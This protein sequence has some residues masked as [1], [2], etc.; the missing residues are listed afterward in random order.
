M[1]I[2]PNTLRRAASA[3]A[4]FRATDEAQ[5]AEKS[6]L[7]N[8][9]HELDVVKNRRASLQEAE[10]RDAAI[11]YIDGE[12]AAPIDKKRQNEL[13][14]LQKSIPALVAALPLQRQRIATCE[15]EKRRLK[16]PLASEIVSLVSD[17][18]APALEHVRT[19]IA[20]LDE[21]LSQLLAADIIRTSLLDGTFPVNEGQAPPFNGRTI[22]EK[23]I[24]ALPSKL[25][26]E[27]LSKH[28]LYEQARAKASGII[29]Q[30]KEQDVIQ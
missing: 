1:D 15:A 2:N 16:G 9:E 26:S 14:K 4:A 18:Q 27:G 29:N 22:V 17:I 21:A 6:K 5:Q 25:M 7:A 24:A 28:R 12:A 8:V 3:F 19:A 11:R 13:E 30:I 23:L 10:D 20:A